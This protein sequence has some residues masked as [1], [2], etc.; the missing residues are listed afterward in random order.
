MTDTAKFWSGIAEKY[1]KSPISDMESYRYTLERTQSHISKDDEVLELGC[2]TASTALL[3]ASHAKR[4]HGTDIA[5]GMIDV[6]NRKIAEE[7]VDNLTLEVGDIATATRDQQYDVVLAFNLLHLLPEAE[8]DLGRIARAVKPGGLFISKTTCRPKGFGSLKYRMIMLVL[9][10]MQLLGK[11]PFVKMR[12][13][14]EL[15]KMI[16]EQGFRIVET[17]NHPVNPPSRYIVARKT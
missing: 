12:R 8:A 13:I 2:G 3:L 7:G 4:Y 11:A 5:Q 10:V 17:G 1:A 9:P 16:T 6:G 15:E 14:E